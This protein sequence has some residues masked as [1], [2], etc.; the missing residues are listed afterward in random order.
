MRISDW[1]SDVCS[2]DL[3]ADGSVAGQVVRA[4]PEDV[5]TAVSVAWDAFRNKPWRH[6]RPDQRA[7]TLF[8]IGR[9]ILAERESLARL[10]ML[11]SGKPYKE[12][13]NMVT[14]AASYFRYYASVCETWQNEV[15]SPRGDRKSTRLNSSH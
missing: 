15:T 5:D 8:E 7:T 14:S 10:Q 12:C 3:P 1:S 11:D 13:M 9:R 2:S 4:T 6:L